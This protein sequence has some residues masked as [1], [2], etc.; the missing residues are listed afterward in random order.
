VGK[1]CSALATTVAV[2]VMLPPVTLADAAMCACCACHDDSSGGE[3]ACI[4]GGV[5]PV[6]WDGASTARRA[7]ERVLDLDAFTQRVRGVVEVA[8]RGHLCNKVF[9]ARRSASRDHTAGV[10]SAVARH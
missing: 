7:G 5:G 6:T 2:E 4:S 9:G 3:R 10:G 8:G 1:S